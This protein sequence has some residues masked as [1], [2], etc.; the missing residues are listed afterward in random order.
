MKSEPLGDVQHPLSSPEPIVRELSPRLSRIITT[1]DEL[2][3]ELPLRMTLESLAYIG[4][5]SHQTWHVTPHDHDHFE[6][7][8]VA[9][10]HGWFALD[11]ALYPVRKGDLFLTKPQEVHQGAALGESPFRLYYLGFHLG[12]MRS[13]EAAFYGLTGLRVVRDQG[14]LIHESYQ[15]LLQELKATEPFRAEMVQGLLLQLLVATLRAYNRSSSAEASPTTLTPAIKRVLDALHAHVGARVEMNA[16]AQLAHLS[17]AQFDREFKR[18]LGMPPGTY[19]RNLCLER[20]QHLLREE[21]ASVS[22]VAEVLEFSSLHTFSIFFKRHTGLSPRAYRDSQ[23]EPQTSA[24]EE[25]V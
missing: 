12:A 22:Q 9:E 7:C 2:R 18:Q 8:F 1:H 14:A 25:N 6:L 5:V 19:A 16:L 23:K 11:T 17:R 24:H 21:D 15:T 13:L 10:G 20:A 3:I 4:V